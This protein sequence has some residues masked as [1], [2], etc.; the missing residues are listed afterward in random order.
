MKATG[1]MAAAVLIVAMGLA[2]HVASAQQLHQTG[3]LLERHI[4]IVVALDQQDRRLPA[5]DR[6]NRRRLVRHRRR[7]ERATPQMN[8]RQVDARLE[9]VRVSRQRLRREYAAV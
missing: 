1:I 2:S 7:I 3:H 9:D 5:V 8:T 4:A 6:P